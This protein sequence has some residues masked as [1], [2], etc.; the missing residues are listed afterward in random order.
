LILDEVDSDYKSMTDEERRA[1]LDQWAKADRES[2]TPFQRYLFDNGLLDDVLR[3]ELSEDDVILEPTNHC[4]DVGC[5]DCIGYW[6]RDG[7]VS[8]CICDHHKNDEDRNVPYNHCEY[9]GCGN[10][11]GVVKDN[12]II[13]YCTCEHHRDGGSDPL[14]SGPL[15]AER[16]TPSVP[17]R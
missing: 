9:L 1:L 17:Q 5:G 16:T 12:T 6:K 8:F 15:D 14:T 10:C 3:P 13:S 2:M 11:L 7:K 4:S